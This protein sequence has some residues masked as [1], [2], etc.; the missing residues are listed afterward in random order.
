MATTFF[1]INEQC[2]LRNVIGATLLGDMGTHKHAGTLMLDEIELFVGWQVCLEAL[3]SLGFQDHFVL[4]VD[5]LCLLV[6]YSN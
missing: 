2:D 3:H 4:L 6:R 5:D 1:A